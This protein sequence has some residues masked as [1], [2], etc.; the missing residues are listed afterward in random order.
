MDHVMDDDHSNAMSTM[1][2]LSLRST[3]STNIMSAF[4]Q[5]QRM[6]AKRR[7]PNNSFLSR[8]D[9]GSS[10]RSALRLAASNGVP[11]TISSRSAVADYNSSS[12]FG[13]RS[14]LCSSRSHASA[15]S[16][17]A[18]MARKYSNGSQGS[19]GTHASH[20]S[21]RHLKGNSTMKVEM[22]QRS[23]GSTVKTVIALLKDIIIDAESSDMEE[24]DDG[25]LEADEIEDSRRVDGL[26]HDQSSLPEAPLQEMAMLSQWA[27]VD[28][29]YRVVISKYQGISTTIKI[30]NLYR[31]N[32]DIQVYCLLTL[33]QLPNKKQINKHGGVEACIQTMQRYPTSIEIQS[34]AFEVLKTQ[35]AALL[36]ESRDSLSPLHELVVTADD[37]YLTQKGRECVTFVK[38]F[39]ETYQIAKAS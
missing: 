2:N 16:M 10:S 38:Q 30:M 6:V 20:D 18:A 23:N 14:R 29:Y 19:Q 4:F 39:L 15:P 35:A 26:H 33:S 36:L 27:S 17:L 13:S 37:L 12:S 7:P 21:I 31:E 22:A 25:A 28:A 8:S 32:P 11:T 9:T 24:D 34:Q 3:G 1:G 5:Q